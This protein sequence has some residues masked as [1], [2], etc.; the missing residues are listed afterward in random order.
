M[1]PSKHQSLSHSSI[2]EDFLGYLQN[3][4]VLHWKAFII[5]NLK[6]I[7]SKQKSLVALDDTVKSVVTPSVTRPGTELTSIQN[8][9]QDMTTIRIVGI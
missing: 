2:V 6:Y 4:N 9:T 5:E 1:F 7:N 8:D 3:N